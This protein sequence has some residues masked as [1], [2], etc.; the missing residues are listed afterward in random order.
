MIR[1]FTFNLDGTACYKFIHDTTG[2]VRVGYYGYEVTYN[3]SIVDEDKLHLVATDEHLRS[4]DNKDIEGGV[5]LLNGTR[6]HGNQDVD[7]TIRNENIRRKV[8]MMND[9]EIQD[10]LDQAQTSLDKD[11]A[12][13]YAIQEIKKA[14]SSNR[15]SLVNSVLNH[16]AMFAEG[17]LANIL[18]AYVMK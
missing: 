13:Y 12:E 7:L 8:V 15:K 11:S 9:L 3:Y 16:L 14:S 5:D 4:F 10:Y 2:V 1:S 18:A 17:T 6:I